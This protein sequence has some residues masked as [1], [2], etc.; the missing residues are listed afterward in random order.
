MIDQLN[1]GI[2]TAMRAK[3]KARLTTLRGIKSVADGIAKKEVRETTSADV[4]NAVLTGVKQ[5]QEAID[6]YIK[7]NREDLADVERSEMAI[8]QEFLPEQLTEEEIIEIVDDAIATLQATS[9]KDMGKVMGYVNGKIAK[10][11]VDGKVVAGIVKSKL[12]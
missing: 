3:D 1:A 7:G 8:L 11:S 9:P 5:R 2:K 6:L 4:E 12:V 10:G